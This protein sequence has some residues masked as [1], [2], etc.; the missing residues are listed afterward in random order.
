M[1][2]Y[3]D[4]QLVKILSSVE[5][6]E[7]RVWKVKDTDGRVRQNKKKINSVEKLKEFIGDS[8]SSVYVSVSQFLNPHKVYGKK[9]KHSQYVTADNLLLKSDLLFDVDDEEDLSLAHKEAKEIIRFMKKKPY[10]LIN[11]RFSGTKGFH[12]LYADNK[13]I[14]ENNPQK[15]IQLY[16]E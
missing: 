15:R 14:S 12:L 9:P 11:I 6:P 7:W 13:K 2:K 16:E 3:N 8:P 4:M 10:R 1:E 5:N